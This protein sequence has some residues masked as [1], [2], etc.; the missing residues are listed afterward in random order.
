MVGRAEARIS[1]QSKANAGPSAALLCVIRLYY[2]CEMNHTGLA[3]MLGFGIV[4]LRNR[5]T[6]KLGV[7]ALGIAT[8][9]LGAR[10]RCRVQ[11]KSL[12]ARRFLVLSAA[13]APL[14][15]EKMYELRKFAVR[16][17]L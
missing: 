7:G 13:V 10:F 4:R 9:Q 2:D 17:R 6:S 16:L 14:E 5:A 12:P 11:G 15:V 8:E 1:N 3:P